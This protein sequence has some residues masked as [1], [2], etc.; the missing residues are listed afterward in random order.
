MKTKTI[1]TYQT[2]AKKI[3]DRKALYWAVTHAFDIHSALYPGC[4]IDIAPSLVIPTVTYVDNFTGAVTFFSD[5]PSIKEYI[6]ENKEYPDACEV[7]FIGQDYNQAIETGQVDL[8]ISQYA[9][10]VGQ[11]TK[12]HLHVGGILLC[13][14]S[15]GDATLA[16]FDEDY[17]FIGI[18]DKNNVI[19]TDDLES[20]FIVPKNKTASIQYVL[21]EMK[22]LQYSVVA[23]NYLFRKIH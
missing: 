18:V 9:G 7:H 10:F 8:L 16:H 23:E 3:G 13:N 11:A 2:Y 21:Q 15:H 22:G 6:Q 1:E 12:A 20:Y 17:E 4:H 14:D 19:Q 5:M